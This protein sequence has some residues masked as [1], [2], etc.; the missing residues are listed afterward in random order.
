M[1]RDRWIEWAR[2]ARDGDDKAFEQLV[3]RFR[4]SVCAAIH[5]ILKDWHLA[6]DVAQETF[7]VAHGHLLELKEVR[8]FRSWLFRIARNRAVSGLRSI[9]ARPARTLVGVREEDIAGFPQGPR[10]ENSPGI[11]A[12]GIGSL[13]D[14]PDRPSREAWLLVRNVLR[15]LPNE[16]GLILTLR[17][18][19]GMSLPEIGDT[20]GRSIQ[21][22]KSALSRAR[23][24]ARVELR[25]AGLSAEKVFHEL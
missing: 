21:G 4:N 17:H 14:E 12:P 7:V 15:D 2:Q 16:Y 18:V 22:V 25:L 6:Q 8:C 23:A 24:R 5:P 9:R 19:E 20:I 13:E 11:D 1:R 3:D 10:D